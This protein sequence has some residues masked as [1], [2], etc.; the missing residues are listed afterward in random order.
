VQAEAEEAQRRE[1]EE[2]AL[3]AVR[4]VRDNQQ[5]HAV[6]K[7]QIEDA[8][9]AVHEQQAE[10]QELG[11]SLAVAD[12]DASEATAALQSM[13]ERLRAITDAALSVPG[14]LLAKLG[15]GG[16]GGRDGVSTGAGA[17]GADDDVQ[18]TA[19]DL[20]AGAAYEDMGLGVGSTAVAL[21]RPRFTQVGGRLA[22]RQA[23]RQ[24][25][26]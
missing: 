10:E 4:E 8:W 24:A 9:S 26:W 6:L 23:G 11:D 18:P 16:S 17:G 20:D 2:R 5:R 19:A 22:G 21:L 14:V 7:V 13:H 15:A 1:A 25:G 12:S 3:L